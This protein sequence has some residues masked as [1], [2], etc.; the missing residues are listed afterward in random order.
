MLHSAQH[1]VPFPLNQVRD[2]KATF[3][4]NSTSSSSSSQVVLVS[5]S[6]LERP[7]G[8][9]VELGCSAWDRWTY[10]VGVRVGTESEEEEVITSVVGRHSAVDLP[11]LA[12][13]A[14]HAFRVRAVSE[15]GKSR[16]SRTFASTSFP[17]VSDSDGGTA[18]VTWA[19][20]QFLRRADLFGRTELSSAAGGVVDV[21]GDGN[22]TVFTN[23]SVL[24]ARREGGEAVVVALLKAGG[25]VQSLALE[26]YARNVYLSIPSRRLVSRVSYDAAHSDREREEVPVLLA[27]ARDLAVDSFLARLCWVS[28]LGRVEC[29][30]LNGEG[31]KGMLALP[32]WSGEIVVGMTVDVDRHTVFAMTRQFGVEPKHRLLSKT[33]WPAGEAATAA[34]ATVESEFPRASFA[35]PLRYFMGKLSW[36]EGSDAIATYDTFG[37]SLSGFKLEEAV[38]TFSVTYGLG[39]TFPEGFG[40]ETLNVV[41]DEVEVGTIEMAKDEEGGLLVWWNPAGGVNYGDVEYRT[42]VSVP[43][44]RGQAQS[45]SSPAPGL[46]LRDGFAEPDTEVRVAVVAVTKWASSLPVERSLRTPEEPPGSP[47]LVQVFTSPGENGHVDFLVRWRPPRRPNGKITGFHISVRCDSNRRVGFC[48][49]T[50][51]VEAGETTATLTFKQE[52]VTLT[53]VIYF[54]I[55]ARNRAGAGEEATRAVNV[56]HPFLYEPSSLLF[57]LDFKESILHLVDA[58]DEGRTVSSSPTYDLIPPLSGGGGGGFYWAAE[59]AFV[60]FSETSS[61]GKTGLTMSPLNQHLPSSPSSVTLAVFDGVVCCLTL[62]F[63]GRSALLLLLSDEGA[64]VQRVRLDRPGDVSV[65]GQLEGGLGLPRK[66]RVDPFSGTLY[67]LQGRR[68]SRFRVEGGKSALRSITA[69]GR[70][71]GCVEQGVLERVVDFSLVPRQFAGL[72]EVMLAAR[73]SSAFRLTEETELYLADREL[74]TCLWKGN[75]TV[76]EDNISELTADLGFVYWLGKGQ[77]AR[78]SLMDLSTGERDS[79]EMASSLDRVDGLAARCRLCQAPPRNEGCLKPRLRQEFLQVAYFTLSVVVH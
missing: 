73:H 74:C 10:E 17:G 31:R 68:L 15:S 51:V 9:D 34:T 38:R 65:V 26:P 42:V 55:A 60:Y 52:E 43:S 27:V 20:G 57:A 16:W 66:V 8:G 24:F 23:G 12:H 5:W 22:V 29:S 56:S 75:T 59:D 62:D 30:G 53:N 79:L 18:R 71:C 48:G 44:L 63:V 50:E 21:A 76:S 72:P 6:P 28:G 11:V 46:R 1:P 67:V 19:S 13:D 25:G 45:F 61:P 14:V 78:V 58:Q 49:R 35:R 3:G 37:K 77:E 7:G 36:I 47:E 70:G 41:P 32:P 64:K 33:L 54:N 40:P 69:D 39:R 2:L 4:F